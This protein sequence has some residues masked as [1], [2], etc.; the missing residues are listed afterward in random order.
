MESLTFRGQSYE[1]LETVDI[2]GFTELRELRFESFAMFNA[3]TLYISAPKLEVLYIGNGCFASYNSGEFTL[4]ATMLY[5][6]TIGNNCMNYVS[7]VYLRNMNSGIGQFYIGSNSLI[8]LSYIRYSNTLVFY[9]NSLRSAVLMGGYHLSGSIE[10]VDMDAPTT[11]PTTLPPTTL[12]PTT[13]PPTTQPPTTLPPTTRPPTTLPPT[14]QPPS[15]Q[16]PV[17]S[18]IA[19]ETLY[20]TISDIPSNVESLTF[21]G[22]S[23]ESL[24]TVDISGFTELRELR[25]ESFAMFNAHTLYI[26]AP[27]LEVLYIGNGCFAS[28][29]SGEFTLDATMLYNVTIG[30][31]C[32]NYVSTVYLRNMNSGIGQFYIGSNSL[33]RLS[34]IRYSNTLVFYANSLRSAV[35]M[36]GYH[37]SGSIELVDMDIPTLIPTLP[38]TTLPP[39]TQ[40]PTEGPTDDPCAGKVTVHLLRS[41]SSYP[42]DESF[43]IY[44]GTEATAEHLVYKQ[45]ICVAGVTQICINRGVH[46]LRMVD[47]YG[48]K[49]SENSVL[50]IYAENREIGAY[51]MDEMGA[52]MDVT[53]AIPED[54]PYASAWRYTNTAMVNSDWTVNNVDWE[55]VYPY[56]EI[57]TITR[58]FRN[59]YVLNVPG[60]FG[61]RVRINTDSGFIFYINGQ[62]AYRYNMPAGEITAGTYALSSGEVTT[63]TLRALLSAYPTEGGVYE[64]AVE[65][66]AA[67]GAASGSETFDCEIEFLLHSE[68][69]TA[70]GGEVISSTPSYST[71]T[72]INMFD[73]LT[74]TKWRSSVRSNDFPVYVNYTFPYGN[75]N[76]LSIYSFTSADQDPAPTCNHWDLL[77]SVD[78]TTWTV[79][80]SRENV[81]WTGRFQ[82]QTFRTNSTVAYNTFS[83]VCYSVV[84]LNHNIY[85]NTIEMS[86]WELL[87]SE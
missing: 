35:L 41:C 39:T 26:S 32:M 44:E 66:H 50:T 70:E 81:E 17:V 74:S 67:E 73:G 13:L 42:E 34:Y 31:N 75:L 56:P 1:S 11:Q 58:Y 78:G 79:V 87:F 15:T 65:V 18:I 47:D 20:P 3:H 64:F 29:N 22:Q 10:L 46:T 49:W 33:I 48:D 6:V 43:F 68:S 77:G 21:R 24:E 72:V 40:P 83:W 14:T 76:M 4:D 2:S 5:N 54:I 38:P 25:F 36:G 12:P 60:F 8:R 61:M 53:F 27:K 23:Y 19:D 16:P 57:S 59:R 30:N 51:Q 55:A 28:Y 82:V 80:D 62:I 45:D 69:L 84:N 37:L 71:D 63:H 9:A 86:E 52:S 7:T 85:G